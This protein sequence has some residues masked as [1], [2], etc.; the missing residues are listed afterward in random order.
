MYGRKDFVDVSEEYLESVCEWLEEWSNQE[1]SLIIAQ[2]LKKHGIGWSYFKHFLA[3]SPQLENTFEITISGLCEKW[4]LYAMEKKNDMPQHMQKIVMKY[5]RVYDNHSYA[6]DLEAKKELAREQ[7]TQSPEYK[8][9]NYAKKQLKGVYKQI[10]EL[11]TD[12]SRSK[13][14]A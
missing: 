8:N 13:Q 6:V 5:L 9:E 12:K 11:N 10:Y 2:F 14:K 1:D 4:L 7:P 3:L